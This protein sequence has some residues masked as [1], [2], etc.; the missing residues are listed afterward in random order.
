VTD[1]RVE[2][3]DSN[4]HSTGADSVNFVDGP[5]GIAV[6]NVGEVCSEVRVTNRLVRSEPILLN[7]HE[8]CGF[9][10]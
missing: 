9:E 8:P 5:E 3:L 10:R 4:G 7:G 6:G 2:A 1:Q